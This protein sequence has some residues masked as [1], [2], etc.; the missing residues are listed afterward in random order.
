MCNFHVMSL[1]NL[2]PAHLPLMLLH[3][4]CPIFNSMLF[5]CSGWSLHYYKKFWRK[6]Q[7]GFAYSWTGQCGVP[8]S[9]A[10]VCLNTNKTVTPKEPSDASK[11]TNNAT[12]VTQD[13]NLASLPLVREQLKH[14]GLLSDAANILLSS[15]QKVLGNHI[16][17]LS[18][19]G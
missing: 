19:G 12:P 5:L 2:I 6:M 18:L 8:Q 3:W 10:T 16:I 15:W 9:N 7:P 1:F 13:S 4:I 11:A 14:S 17:L